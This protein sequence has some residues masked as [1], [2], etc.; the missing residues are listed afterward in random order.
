M[1]ENALDKVLI[2]WSRTKLVFK[3]LLLPRWCVCVCVCVCVSCGGWEWALGRTQFLIYFRIKRTIFIIL[4]PFVPDS[5]QVFNCECTLSLQRGEVGTL[6]LQRGEVGTMSLQRGEVGTMSLQRGEVGTMM[7][8]NA[9]NMRRHVQACLNLG[10]G[11]A[12]L[13]SFAD[14]YCISTRSTALMLWK[15]RLKN[16]NLKI[17]I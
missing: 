5:G 10:S 2:H 12:A 9:N 1:K 15:W 8:A 11:H 13:L 14:I 7:W 6:S 3:D 4:I 16:R 17:F